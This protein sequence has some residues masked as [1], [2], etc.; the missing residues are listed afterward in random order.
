MGYQDEV[1]SE[2][3]GVTDLVS[4]SSGQLRSAKLLFSNPFNVIS[5]KI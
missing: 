1:R 3:A 2:T 4:E 5:L